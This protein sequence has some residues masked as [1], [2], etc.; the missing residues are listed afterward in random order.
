MILWDGAGWHRGS[1]V[2]KFIQKD[3]HIEIIYF[4][5]YTPKL[6]PQ[7]HVWKNGRNQVT[8]NKF[9]E[10]IDRTTDTFVNY[11]NSNIFSYSLLDFSDIS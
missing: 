3:G 5:R 2:Q 10:D 4:P 7:E 8:H 1:K 9:I 6:N 11:L